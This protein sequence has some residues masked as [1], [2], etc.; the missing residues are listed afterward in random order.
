MA[1]APF[2]RRE[3]TAC[4]LRANK[5]TIANYREK[6]ETQAYRYSLAIFETKKNHE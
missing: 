1:S 5:R 6:M 3:K 2:P 4:F